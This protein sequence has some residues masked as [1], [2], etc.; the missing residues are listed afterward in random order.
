MD[1][2]LLSL[3]FI[4]KGEDWVFI[5]QL[6]L[7]HFLENEGLFDGNLWIFTLVSLIL[8]TYRDTFLRI[9]RIRFHAT[10]VP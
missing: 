9:L 4:Y 6:L 5:F 10:K 1:G 8:A 7:V 3:D 2:T